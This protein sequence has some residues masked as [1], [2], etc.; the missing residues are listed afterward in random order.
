MRTRS[1]QTIGLLICTLLSLFRWSYAVSSIDQQAVPNIQ[2]GLQADSP[3]FTAALFPAEALDRRLDSEQLVAR[4]AA[5]TI[6]FAYVSL[7][8]AVAHYLQGE[9]LVIVA[10]SVS[11]DHQTWVLATQPDLIRNDPDTVQKAVRQF[12]AHSKQLSA[13]PVD[14][15]E[16][17]IVTS[18]Q[19]THPSLAQKK[20]NISW[21][22]D[23]SFIAGNPKN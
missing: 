6:K 15:S 23:R 10:G 22:I 14:L 12:Y 8:T 20:V 4:L 9:P 11:A 18:I 19:Q 21:L 3:F 17:T 1:L 13:T 5:K 16:E 2:A 7:D